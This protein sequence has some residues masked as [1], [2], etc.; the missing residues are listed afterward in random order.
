MF[1]FFRDLWVA[2]KNSELSEAKAT[3]SDLRRTVKSLKEQIQQY[4]DQ[5]GSLRDK[6]C[7]LVEQIQ[8]LRDEITGLDAVNVGYAVQIR[9]LQAQEEVLKFE[10]IALNESHKRLAF[11]SEA[12]RR[13]A[14]LEIALKQAE[15]ELASVTGVGKFQKEKPNG[16]H[17]TVGFE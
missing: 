3:A 8:S 13:E 16:N 11:L 4:Q 14:E 5:E 17:D 2:Y 9:K 1:K 7:S 6:I 10:I 12:S 15:I